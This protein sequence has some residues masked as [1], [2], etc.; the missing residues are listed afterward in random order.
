M[1]VVPLEEVNEKQFFDFLDKERIL[2]IFT[3]YDLK[4][5]REKTRVW[6]AFK[7]GE[8]CGYLFEFDKRI[9]HNTEL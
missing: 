3:I 1:K 2:H 9:V 4:F 7:D 8:I 6:V 5:M